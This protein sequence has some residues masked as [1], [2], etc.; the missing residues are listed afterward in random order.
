MLKIWS[1]KQEQQKSEAAAG[2]TKKKKV[3]AAQLRVQKDLGELALGSTMKTHFPNADDILNFTLTLTPD[4]G[5]YKGGVFNFTFAI[6]STFPHEPPKVKCKE[7]IYHPNIDLEGNVCLNILREDWKPVLNLNAVIVGLQFLFLEPNASDP[8]NKEAAAD[9][10]TD[11]DRFK[12]NVR[13]SM[14]GGS[15]K[16][17]TFDRVMK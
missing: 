4:E 7:K 11:R 14:S 17:E 1:M 15:V 2:Q 10:Q 5:L 3:T 8:L 6:P 9:L 12:R 13:S 16:G